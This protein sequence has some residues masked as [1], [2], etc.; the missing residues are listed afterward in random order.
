MH[1][2]LIFTGKLQNETAIITNRIAREITRASDVEINNNELSLKINLE[3]QNSSADYHWVRYKSYQ[4]AQGKELGYKREIIADNGGEREFTRIDSLLSDLVSFQIN[5]LEDNIIEI[6]ICRA[7]PFKSQKCYQ[8]T[9][10]SQRVSG[11][12]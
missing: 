10:F 4:S 1:H 8:Q 11:S 3:P 6:I 5:W 12:D 7:G 2:S 9:V